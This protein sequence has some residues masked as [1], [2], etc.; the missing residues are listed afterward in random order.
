M[1]FWRH[2]SRADDT[3]FVLGPKGALTHTVKLSAA[4]WPSVCMHEML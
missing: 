2:T 4:L 1:H 3:T